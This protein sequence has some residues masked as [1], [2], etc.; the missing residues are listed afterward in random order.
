MAHP[1]QYEPQMLWLLRRTEQVPDTNG[2]AISP[3]HLYE[4]HETLFNG[5]KALKP[6][7][8]RFNLNQYDA[9]LPTARY[10][11]GFDVSFPGRQP[12]PTAPSSSRAPSSLKI[13]SHVEN[14][15]LP[16][17]LKKAADE[18]VRRPFLKC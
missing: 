3:V 5:F 17:L 9:E 2:Q 7:A 18:D 1:G 14:L 13:E 10:Y 16:F 8:S 12:A 4:R 11:W 15:P 6:G